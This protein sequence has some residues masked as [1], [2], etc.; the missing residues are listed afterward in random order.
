MIK[1]DSKNFFVI[2][3]F[4]V[5]LLATV[6]RFYN[7][8]LRWQLAY[9]Q[10]HD[11][12]IARY[13]VAQMQLP[14]LGPFSSAGAFQTGGEWYWIVML[15]TILFPF[16][17]NG[18]WIFMTFLYVLFVFLIILLARELVGKTFAIIVGLL[19]AVSTAQIAQS[20]SLTNQ[21][22]QAIFSLFAIFCSIRFL[23]TKK[24]IY[25]FFLA[26]FVSIA[27]SIHLQG[28]ALIMLVV[29]TLIFSGIPKISSIFLVGL[30]LFL[31]WVPVLV[32]GAVVTCRNR[33][34]APARNRRDLP[35]RSGRRSCPAARAAGRSRDRRRTA[36]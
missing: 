20:V 12:L 13:A 28:A 33:P 2:G 5:I 8:D 16:T 22:P 31:P 36:A 11:A 34:R 27:A 4:A 1:L 15:G 6:L 32:A 35:A 25:L 24:R 17:V 21:S 9:D 14:L 23:R 10:A 29:F 26:L 7:Y 19:A 18:P 3:V 30:G